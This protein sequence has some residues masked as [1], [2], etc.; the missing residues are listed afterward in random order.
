MKAENGA[1][2]L[3]PSECKNCE[4]LHGKSF[5]V[6]ICIEINVGE[7]NHGNDLELEIMKVCPYEKWSV[8]ILKPHE[9]EKKTCK[10]FD[11]HQKPYFNIISKKHGSRSVSLNAR[12]S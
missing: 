10:T 1:S 5:E 3:R 9:E 4:T 8:P 6:E 7:K 12:F 2:F 11:A